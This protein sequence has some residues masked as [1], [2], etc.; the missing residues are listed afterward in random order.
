MVSLVLSE[1]NSKYGLFT[2]AIVPAP[3]VTPLPRA[4]LLFAHPDD[5]TIALGARLSNFT[6]AHIVHVTDG[7]P[8]NEEDRRHH[9]FATLA[10]YRKARAFELCTALAAAGLSSVSRECLRVPDQEASQH[11]ALLTRTIARIIRQ[12]QPE[13]IFTHPYEGGHPD[14]DSCAFAVRHALDLLPSHSVPLVIEAAFYHLGPRGREA[15]IFLPPS[16]RPVPS[17]ELRLSPEEHRR[18]RELLA[19]FR[20]QRDTLAGFPLDFER[21]RIAPEYDFLNPPHTPPVLYDQYAWGMT[22]PE[23]SRLACEAEVVLNHVPAEC[24]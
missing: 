10:D 11:L 6:D 8:R 24:R 1:A 14:H 4:L 23:F 15:G 12:Q 16:T 13:V 17:V 3:A 22:S 7:A 9:G 5:E 19:R 18:K 21:F 2:Q 20:S